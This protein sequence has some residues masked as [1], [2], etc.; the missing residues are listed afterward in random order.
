MTKTSVRKVV[1]YVEIRKCYLLNADYTHV[2]AI[3]SLLSIVD[4]CHVPQKIRL[5]IV[6]AKI[7]AELNATHINCEEYAYVLM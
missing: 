2:A 7:R 6:N 4:A 5:K 1:R 3:S